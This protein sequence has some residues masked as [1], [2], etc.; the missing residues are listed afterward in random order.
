MADDFQPRWPRYGLRGDPFFSNALDPDEGTMYPIDLF[1]GRG[2]E[3]KA[4]LAAIADGDHSATLI[5]AG[6]GHGKTTLANAVCFQLM[7]KNYLVLPEEVQYEPG[8]GLETF[9]GRLLH[10]ILQAL[11]DRG[12]KLPEV[13]ANPQDI[14]TQQLSNLVKARLLVRISRIRTGWGGGL[15]AGLAGA[16]V[17]VQYDVL[18][19]YFEPKASRALLQGVVKEAAAL[20]PTMA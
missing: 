7:R 13:P 18:Q 6:G 20:E 14:E 2:K 19:P 5:Y 11:S 16:N 1:H 10:G 9:F 12:H 3:R 15:Q 4:L 17:A 8:D